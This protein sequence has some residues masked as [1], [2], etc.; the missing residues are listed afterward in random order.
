MLRGF[1]W[2]RLEIVPA[3]GSELPR[4]ELTFLQVIEKAGIE[5]QP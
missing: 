4:L 2:Q 1:H 5:E 3:T